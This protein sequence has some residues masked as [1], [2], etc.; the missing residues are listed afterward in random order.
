MESRGHVQMR[1]D[2]HGDHEGRARYNSHFASSGVAAVM[3]GG[4]GIG[5]A[6]AAATATPPSLAAGAGR[7]ASRPLVSCNSSTG[8]WAGLG[9]PASDPSSPS[10]ASVTTSPADIVAAPELD[11]R[12]SLSTPRNGSDWRADRL[13]TS[14]PSS[15]REITRSSLVGAAA[16]ADAEPPPR[17]P[18]QGDASSRHQSGGIA[19][20]P[21]SDLRDTTATSASSLIYGAADA[22]PPANGAPPPSFLRTRSSDLY[23]SD[24]GAS[25][26]H[27]ALSAGAAARSEEGPTS[28]ALQMLSPNASLIISGPPEASEEPT[29]SPVVRRNSVGQEIRMRPKS[30]DVMLHAAAGPGAIWTP[31]QLA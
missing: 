29:P 27:R 18:S 3:G 26:A 15:S 25:S 1:V 23:A 6:P 8:V 13:A 21:R 4:G 17:R 24:A 16:V 31:R 11:R 10:T 28:Y 5:E 2:P 22:P 12:A 19:R 20:K 30:P 7:A 14:T 9:V